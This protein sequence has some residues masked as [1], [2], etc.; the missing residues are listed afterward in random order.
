[1]KEASS[2]MERK[3]KKVV[4]KTREPKEMIYS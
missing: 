3:M 1:M 4:R 2:V